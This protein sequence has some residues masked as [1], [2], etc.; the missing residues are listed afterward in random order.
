[1]KKSTIVSFLSILIGCFFSS[2]NYQDFI[3][4]ICCSFLIFIFAFVFCKSVDSYL[5]RRHYQQIA[6]EID[7]L[8][9]SD[10]FLTVIKN[11]L[12]DNDA[13]KQLHSDSTKKIQLST[14]Q[15]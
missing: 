12:Q 10:R 11:G 1:M 8:L 5:Q 15:I 14:G 9:L 2:E 3:C 4:L 7:R 6:N 13:N